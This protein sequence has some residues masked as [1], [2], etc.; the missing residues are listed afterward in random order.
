MVSLKKKRVLRTPPTTSLLR[1]F[2]C[3]KFSDRKHQ[4]MQTIGKQLNLIKP[5][6]WGVFT[7]SPS[8]AVKWLL[9]ILPRI[10]VY[11][12]PS[13]LQTTVV[14]TICP[15]L[16]HMTWLLISKTVIV[17]DNAFT[18]GAKELLSLEARGSTFGAYPLQAKFV[19]YVIMASDIALSLSVK[20]WGDRKGLAKTYG[21]SSAW[22]AP[23]HE[24]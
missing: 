16:L 13:C 15:C 18:W 23:N 21:S 24:G 14:S 6:R 19:Q 12:W 5:R 9:T 17:W 8:T 20:R 1:T 4:I 22:S 2:H 10:R 7:T 11:F 3:L